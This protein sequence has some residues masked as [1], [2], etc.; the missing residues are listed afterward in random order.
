MSE[1]PNVYEQG[2]EQ[3]IEESLLRPVPIMDELRG[4]K[5]GYNELPIDTLHPKFSEPVVDISDY[6]IAGQGYYSRP[7]VATGEAVPGA[8]SNLYLRRSVVETL[9]KINI[10]LK[11]PILSK[12][13]GGDVELYV[14]DALRPIVLQ[15][16]LH[17]E[18]IPALIRKNHPELTEDQ[19]TERIK[20]IIAV[21]SADPKKPS[22]HATGG[23]LD[24]ILRYKQPRSGYVEGSNVP[25][26]HLDGDTSTRINPDFFEQHE[27]NNEEEHQAQRNRRAYYA[28][29]TGS[30]FGVDTGL[31]NNPT[32][33]WHWGMGDQLSAKV[34]GYESAYYSL[35][36]PA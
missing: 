9:A 23:A 16:R 27:P 34:S 21:P 28:I 20:D 14:E 26:G 10:T 18:L 8:P 1:V 36:E 2:F 32:E 35:T 13:F 30:A 25:V 5:R 29:M 15:M 22:P 24:I 11:N 17:D 7:N 19:I 12:F 6:G 33:W 31:V 4:R 3:V